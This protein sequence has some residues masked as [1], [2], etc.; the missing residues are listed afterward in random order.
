MF[1]FPGGENLVMDDAIYIVQCTLCLACY[2]IKC[3]CLLLMYELPA[4]QTC[5]VGDA[6]FLSAVRS[7][8]AER[9]RA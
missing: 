2:A 5:Y 4:V 9:A 8:H 1:T 6:N 7:K 3:S